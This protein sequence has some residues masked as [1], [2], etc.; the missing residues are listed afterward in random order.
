MSDKK[1]IFSVEIFKEDGLYKTHFEI[2]TT[3]EEVK[4]VSFITAYLQSLQL[5]VLNNDFIPLLKDPKIE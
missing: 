3:K 2:D 1:I 5:D 4:D